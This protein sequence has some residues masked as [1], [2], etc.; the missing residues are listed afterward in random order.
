MEKGFRIVVVCD[1]MLDNRGAI[2]CVF[3]GLFEIGMY[4]IRHV[5]QQSDIDSQSAVFDQ[6]IGMSSNKLLFI[7]SVM[8]SKIVVRMF[9]Y[10]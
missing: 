9:E 5:C 7:N 10:V 1:D 3:V 2:I 6:Q 4:P 8:V